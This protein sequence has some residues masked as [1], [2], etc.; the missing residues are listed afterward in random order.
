METWIPSAQNQELLELLKGQVEVEWMFHVD[1]EPS[2]LPL[3]KRVLEIERFFVE[4]GN[5][6]GSEKMRRKLNEGVG[7]GGMVRGGWRI[8][9]GMAE[10]EGEEYVLFTGWESVDRYQESVRSKRATAYEG[11]KD[12][13]TGID[14]DYAVRLE[15]D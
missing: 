10:G 11:I 3:G 13:V 15:M 7:K 2:T 1:V 14:S 9:K 4:E 8:E 12:T 5:K 6:V